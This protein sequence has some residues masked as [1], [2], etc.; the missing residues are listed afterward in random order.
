M[1]V[2][3]RA[4]D[5][6]LDRVVALKL[7]PA[8]KVAEAD[9]KRRFVQEAQ[10]A[11]ALSHPNIVTIYGIDEVDGTD[12]IAMELIAGAPLDRLIP[13]QGLPLTTALRYAVQIADALAAAHAAGIVHRDL[14]PTNV[15]VT[16]SGLVK[17]LDFGLAKLSEDAARAA[18][19]NRETAANAR[20]PGTDKGVIVGTV[21][22]MSPEQAEGRPVDGR[23][24]VFSFGAVLY[25]MVT[26]RKAFQGDSRLATLSAILR[27]EPASVSQIVRDVPKEL[28]RVLA[29]C[30]RKDAARRF[31]HM[32]D[33]KVALEE[34]NEESESGRLLPTPSLAQ[35][36][37]RGEWRRRLIWAG[38]LLSV[39]VVVAA[40]TVWFRRTSVTSTTTDLAAVPLT[41]YPGFEYSPSFSPDGTQVAFSWNGESQDNLDIYVKLVGPGPP[42]LRLTTNPANDSTP[43]WSP[44]GRFIAFQR[45]VPGGRSLVLLVAP[46]G[47]PE[48]TVGVGQVSPNVSRIPSTIAW[49]PDSLSLLVINQ[50]GPGRPE[51]VFLLP[52]DGH[53]KTRLTSPPPGSWDAFPALSPDGRTLAFSRIN[54]NAAS[55]ILEVPLS[56]DLRPQGAPRTLMPD[57]LGYGLAWTADGRDV[58]A[59]AA[60]NSGGGASYL[61]RIA[62]DGSRA[63]R[64]LSVGNDCG[65]PSVSAQGGRLAYACNTTDTNV[66]RIDLDRAAAAVQTH[67]VD[68]A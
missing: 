46:T 51:G 52:L 21:A 40:L 22:Y 34:L 66:W 29:R 8:A 20:T 12:F 30:L 63:P 58:I 43:A 31:Q 15:M 49:T 45:A 16:P 64:R 55:G 23:S 65:S 3:Y 50:D 38:G 11:S 36:E 37:A 44:D 42:P 4:R 62:G 53:E 56:S 7:L 6:Q 47:G 17:V 28:E 5:R 41:T 61:W 39:L 26:G 10:A 13:R 60:S 14:K 54:R 57:S 18:T 19:A 33:V 59:A 68:T 35:P 2:V 24:D 9:S 1:G 32:A 25:E 67:L 48:R 27:D